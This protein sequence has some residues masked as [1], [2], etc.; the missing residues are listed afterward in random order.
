MELLATE[1]PEIDSIQE[2]VGNY[3]SAYTYM[4]DK[5]SK[6]YAREYLIEKIDEETVR[7]GK[8]ELEQINKTFHL[9]DAYGN[10]LIVPYSLLFGNG[11]DFYKKIE[12][13]GLE[14]NRPPLIVREEDMEA[15]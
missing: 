8:G 10:K 2:L 13:N 5:G 7:N 4:D 14:A 6:A 15:E 12:D 3:L 11:V 1:M 9:L